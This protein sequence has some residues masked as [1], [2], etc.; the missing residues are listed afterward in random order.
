MPKRS[1]VETKQTIEQILAAALQQMLT[2]GYDAMSYS[3][4][5]H[6]TGISRTGI[7]HH[8]RYKADFLNLLEPQLAALLIEHLDFSCI[9]S[10]QKSWLRALEV[11]QFC[12]IIKLF[13]AI[14]GSNQLN[15]AQ[16]KMLTLLNEKVAVELGEIGGATIDTLLGQSAIFVFKQ[17]GQ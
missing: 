14:C 7:S 17:N 10:L 3:T 11:P 13:F 16:Y 5:S 6:A 15:T 12:A 8:F 1:R 2:I 9:E 4:L